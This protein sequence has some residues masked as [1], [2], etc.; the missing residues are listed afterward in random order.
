MTLAPLEMIQF[1]LIESCHRLFPGR[2]PATLSRRALQGCAISP[3]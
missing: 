1:K 2:H 3:H